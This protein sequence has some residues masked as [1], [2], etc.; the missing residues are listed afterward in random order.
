M[1]ISD[2]DHSE[3]IIATTLLRRDNLYG[4]AARW[5]KNFAMQFSTVAK[6]D[7]FNHYS[8]LVVE[9]KLSLEIKENMDLNPSL[10]TS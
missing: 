9:R 1:I 4:F 3:K 10:V 6:S 7:G 8:L 2:A 5:F